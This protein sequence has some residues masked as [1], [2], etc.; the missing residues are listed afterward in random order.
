MVSAADAYDL[1]QQAMKAETEEEKQT[2]MNQSASTLKAAADQA[3]GS[4]TT[5][6]LDKQTEQMQTLIKRVDRGINPITGQQEYEFLVGK[7]VG[8]D[9]EW[10]KTGTYTNQAAAQK[11]AQDLGNKNW[12]LKKHTS[13]EEYLQNQVDGILSDSNTINPD[14]VVSV[15][16]DDG[17]RAVTRDG[18]MGPRRNTQEE[19]IAATE[20]HFGLNNKVAETAEQRAELLEL[21]TKAKHFGGTSVNTNQLTNIINQA[22]PEAGRNEASSIA[23]SIRPA[24][25]I[26]NGKVYTSYGKDIDIVLEK[27]TTTDDYKFRLVSPEG[28]KLTETFLDPKDIITFGLDINKVKSVMDQYKQIKPNGVLP[29]NAH[30]LHETL[31]NNLSGSDFLK[32]LQEQSMIS[33]GGTISTDGG[34]AQQLAP[35]EKTGR[36]KGF[37]FYEG[38]ED[39]FLQST[40]RGIDNAI[41]GALLYG[42]ITDTQDYRPSY[43]PESYLQTL[44]QAYNTPNNNITFGQDGLQYTFADGTSATWGSNLGNLDAFSA[45]IGLTPTTGRQGAIFVEAQQFGNAEEYGAFRRTQEQTEE[46]MAPAVTTPTD[47]DT[48][49]DTTTTDTDSDTGIGMGDDGTSQATSPEDVTYTQEGGDTYTGTGS[50]QPTFFGT[51]GTGFVPQ[52]GTFVLGQDTGTAGTGTL[53]GT[54]VLGGTT[55]TQPDTPTVTQDQNYEVR[56]FRNAS[57]MTTSITFV[58]G[59]PT[60]PIPAGF[61]PADKQTGQQQQGATT[62]PPTTATYTA[63][64]TPQVSAPQVRAPTPPTVTPVTGYT[65]QFNTTGQGTNMQQANNQQINMNQGGVV[66]HMPTASSGRF[67]GFKPEAMQRIA[68]SLGYSGDMNGFNGYLNN[69]PDK[70]QRMDNYV[71]RA[72]Q[73]AE[74]GAIIRASN[75]VYVNDPNE[76]L[77]V[78]PSPYVEQSFAPM[79]SETEVAPMYSGTE[80]AGTE[81][82]TVSL[83][84]YDPRVLNQQYIP[85]QGDFT[86]KNITDVQA[87]LAKTPG[88]PT[89]AT[90]VPVGTQLE[91][92]QLVNPY[93]G[94]VTG[95]YALPTTLATTTQ[96]MMPT[97][98]DPNLMSAVEGAGAI[99]GALD[100]TQ[101]AQLDQVA[102]IEGQQLEESSLSNLKAAQGTGIAMDNPVQREIQDGELISGVAN[103][104]KAAQFTEQIE[105]ATAEPSQK[106]TVAGQLEGLMQQFEGG[107]NPPWAAASMRNAMATLAKRGLGAS[108]MAGQAV[109][110]AAMVAALP[111]AQMDAQTQAQFESQNLSNRQQRAMLAAQQRAQFLGQEFDQAFQARVANAAKISDVANMN[112]TAEQ[113]VA[114]ENSRIANTMN[115]ANLSNNQAMVMAEAAAL[116]NLDMANLNNRQQA[117]VQNAQNFLQA[118]LANLSNKQQMELFKGQQRTQALFTDQAALNAAAQ[119]N[120]TSQNQ[121]DQFFA[122]LQTQTSQFNAAQ[123]NAQAQFNTGQVNVIERFNAE[124]NNQRDQFNATNRLVIDQANAQWRRQIATADTAAVNRANEINAQALL[125]YSQSAYNNLWQFYADNMEWAWTSAENERGRISNQA[126]AQLQA[127]T[128][129]SIEEFKADAESSAGIGGFLGDLL[130]SDLKDT[131]AGSLLGNFGFS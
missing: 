18:Q 36:Y 35:Q 59:K 127:D 84:Q 115:L 13:I 130:T 26:S 76:T 24:V 53:G 68:Q 74:G 8:N 41:T 125:G 38:Q 109:I 65:P 118:D 97:T 46:T 78:N 104:E 6:S 69:N 23:S 93:S 27:Y 2:L 119:F 71:Q 22:I 131:V 70:K 72:R 39:E 62:T 17:Y 16:Y 117:A 42:I 67:G 61:Y 123:A 58:N 34:P 32:R 3:G 107:N 96:A 101:A 113:Q 66:P 88:L 91:E 7:G 105:A 9:I 52:T 40:Y 73:M 129:M 112:F 25:G 121:V 45:M 21:A 87:D 92:G 116:A 33:G 122:S 28:V 128:T 79:Y 98:G 4:S 20:K 56:L 108:S 106:A 29:G 77:T 50:Y 82:T 43:T 102:T 81:S 54:T 89:G 90:V 60:T 10:K 31:N 110:Q 83:G 80:G 99:E 64:T 100:K 63:P 49:T 19:A 15:I 14:E 120:A 75:G 12:N 48:G 37:G 55:T 126:I 85:Q 47:T 95:D 111:I 44:N 30:I 11:A 51:D 103:A 114:L 1:L 57:G 86:G 94:Q 124:I 5:P